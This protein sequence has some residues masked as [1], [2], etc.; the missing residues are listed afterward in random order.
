MR[1]R[2]LREEAIEEV[3]DDEHF[4]IIRSVIPTKQE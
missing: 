4:N 2:K 3:Q 1:V